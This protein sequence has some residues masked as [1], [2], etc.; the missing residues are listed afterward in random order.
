MEIDRVR[1]TYLKRLA[2]HLNA[3]PKDPYSPVT[4]MPTCIRRVCHYRI[5]AS[6][7]SQCNSSIGGIT[8]YGAHICLSSIEK[9]EYLCSCHTLDVIDESCS[10]IVTIRLI[11]LIGMPLCISTHKIGDLYL[12]YGFT[13]CIF[14]SN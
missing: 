11:S 3:T 9:F 10:L 6:Q 14:A 1:A 5:S 7:P 2:T 4:D 12:S 13:G 8:A